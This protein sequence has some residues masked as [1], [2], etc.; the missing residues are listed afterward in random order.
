MSGNDVYA[1]LRY[2]QYEGVRPIYTPSQPGVGDDHD[3]GIRFDQRRVRISDA[4]VAGLAPSL[5]QQ[6]FTLLPGFDATIEQHN[7][8]ERQAGYER[9]LLDA[10]LSFTGAS[11][12]WVFDHTLRSDSASVRSAQSIR[13]PAAFVHNDYTDASARKR[14]LELVEQHHYPY[15]H[16][17]R[18]AIVNAWRP[19]HNPA[20]RSPLACCDASTLSPAELVAT[21]RRARERVGELEMVTW[22]DRHR[23]YYFPAM[24]PDELLLIKTHDSA[25]LG[26]ARCA[27]HSAFDNPLATAGAPPRQSLESR[28]LLV[29]E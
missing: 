27:V 12:G 10:L 1:S 18:F 3:I 2:L 28:A 11:V 22:S 17:Q 7:F 29:F 9:N 24:Q 8:A 16:Q 20:L 26:T 14:L 25:P 19:L 6:G 5:H 15:R 4:R 23:W 13:E 21:E